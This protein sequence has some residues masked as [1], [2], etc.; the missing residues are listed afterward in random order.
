MLVIKT[1]TGLE[2]CHIIRH[3]MNTFFQFKRQNNGN[4]VLTILLLEL[5]SPISDYLKRYD[6]NDDNCLP[7]FLYYVLQKLTEVGSLYQ[8]PSWLSPSDSMEQGNR[9]IKKWQLNRVDIVEQ[10]PK[11]VIREQLTMQS[12][13]KR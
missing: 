11:S 10:E 3:I 7:L 9:H 2:R 6:L 8:V 13:N 1:E 12:S 4:A 5:L